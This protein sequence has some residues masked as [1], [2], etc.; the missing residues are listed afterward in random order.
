MH[1]TSDKYLMQIEPK[2]EKSSIPVDDYLTRRMEKLL[3]SAK[4]GASYMGFHRCTGCGEPS[5][6]K[7]LIVDEKYISNSLSAH[8]LRWHRSEVPLS[9]INKLAEISARHL[10]K[11]IMKMSVDGLSGETNN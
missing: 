8:Y 5:G 1:N 3:R 7:D 2:K 6:N 10:F 9:E 11:V 4:E